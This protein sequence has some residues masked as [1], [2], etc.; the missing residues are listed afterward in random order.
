MTVNICYIINKFKWDCCGWRRNLKELRV[1]IRIRT[2]HATRKISVDYWL[3][4]TLLSTCL[5]SINRRWWS[6]DCETRSRMVDRLVGAGGT[7]GSAW[8]LR[9]PPW[10]YLTDPL[11]QGTQSWS[12]LK[13]LRLTDLPGK[14]SIKVDHYLLLMPQPALS[15]S[16]LK[17]GRKLINYHVEFSWIISSF[18]FHL[19][20][21]SVS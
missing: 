12:L 7:L 5:R 15:Y 9:H 20:R 1:R 14:R 19:E 6:P 21:D 11:L 17:V 4:F 3:L 8:G 16:F 10:Q 18:H 13:Q 2:S